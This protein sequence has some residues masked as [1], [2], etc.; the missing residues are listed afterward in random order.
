MK[1]WSVLWVVVGWLLWIL[2]AW[3]GV[4]DVDA[5]LYK[6]GTVVVTATKVESDTPETGSSVTVITADEIEK[7]G[8]QTLLEV[9]QDVPGL[10]IMQHGPYGGTASIYLRGTKPGHTLVML[11]GIELNDTMKTDRS[12]SISHLLVD[13]IERIEI[14]RGAQS[15]LTDQ[16]PWAVSSTSSQRKVKEKQPWTHYL[17]QGPTIPSLKKQGFAVP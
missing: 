8:K 17:K 9:L 7:K 12:A 6:M 15:T 11:D 3:G 16:M 1:H 14:V 13:N 4:R 5:K 2:P 10:S